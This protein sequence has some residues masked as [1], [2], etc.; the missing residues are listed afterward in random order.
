MKHLEKNI[1]ENLQELR[2]DKDFLDMTPKSTIHKRKTID[3]MVC[4]QNEG[5]LFETQY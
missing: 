1:G 3:K 2:L 5:L 4:H